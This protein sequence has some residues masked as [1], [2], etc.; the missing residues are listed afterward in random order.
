MQ[1]HGRAQ[2]RNLHA[3]SSALAILTISIFLTTTIIA[4]L[5]G[6]PSFIT[7]VKQ[8]IAY[9]LVILVLT[10]ATIG[11]SGTRLAG[12]STAPIIRRKRRRMAL[13]AANGVFILVPCALILA[14]LATQGAF[15]IEF[16]LVQG[17]ELIAG[18]ANITLLVRNARL[19]KSMSR[20]MVLT[21][22]RDSS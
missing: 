2:L 9:G 12:S 19:G 6:D 16:Y 8:G 14:W 20:S 4:E 1:P 11:I 21:T 22:A 3:I 13:I 10:M 5:S 17:I 7:T 18:S 15:S